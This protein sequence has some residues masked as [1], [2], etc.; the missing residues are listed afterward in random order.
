[1]LIWH[2]WGQGCFSSST[3]IKESPESHAPQIACLLQSS[4]RPESTRLARRGHMG[5]KIIENNML[6]LRS[7]EFFCVLKQ[8]RESRRAFLA[9]ITCDQFLHLLKHI[10]TNVYILPP[11][12]CFFV[13][14]MGWKQ[15]HTLWGSAQGPHRA[16]QATGLQLRVFTGHCRPPAFV[17]R[18]VKWSEM[19]V[20]DCCWSSSPRH[21]VVKRTFL[22][23]WN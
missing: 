2:V 8:A 15:T 16:L 20:M 6:D 5:R 14:K 18:L 22:R 7:C 13:C 3:N 9:G 12:L 19:R 11:I 23:Y 17:L 10:Q 21:P 1:M 4:P